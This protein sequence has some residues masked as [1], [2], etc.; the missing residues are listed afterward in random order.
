MHPDVTTAAIKAAETLIKFRIAAAPVDPLPILKQLPGVIVVP[1]TEIAE[2]LGTD[3]KQ[4]LST[5]EEAKD[6][7]TFV[8]NIRGRLKYFVIYN[9]RLPDYLRQRALARELGHILLGHDGSRPEDVRNEEALYFARHL[10]CPR[11]VLHAVQQ[12]GIPLTVEVVGNITGCYEK[13]ISGMQKTP[14]ANVP[15]QLNKIVREQFA[16]YIADFLDY[17]RVV[18]GEDD[19]S[20][21]NFGTFMDGYCE[22]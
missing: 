22:E 16:D 6:A 18:A 3:R 8:E 12:S 14:G 5:F 1:Y 21:A 4:I 17:L 11:P 19:T 2:K 7:V 9:R 15:A 10:I 13:C 20:L